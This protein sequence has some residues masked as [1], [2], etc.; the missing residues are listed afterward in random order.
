MVQLVLALFAGA[1]IGPQQTPQARLPVSIDVTTIR[2]L[3][4]QHD[5]RWP[6]LDTVARDLVEQV[7]GNSS[8]Q[9]RDPVT[10]ILAWTFDPQTWMYQ[11]VFSIKN[12]ELR[13][14][15]KLSDT[16]QAF[17]YIELI[18]HKPLLSLIDDLAHIERGRKLNPLEA[19][20]SDINEKL[21]IFQAIIS[22]WSI[23]LIPNPDDEG[24]DWKTIP[25]T[26]GDSAEKSDAEAAFSDLRTAFLADGGPAFAAASERLAAAL[27]ALPA[28]TRPTPE[29]IRTELLYNRIQPFR[30]AWMV[31]AVGA[32]LAALALFVRRKWF[33]GL[34][35]AG[36]M[37]GF[38][39]L[40]YGLWLRWQVAGRI[41]ASNMFESLLFLSWGM[42]LFAILAICVFR[43][44]MIP[45]TASFMAA[46][47]LFLADI[48]PLDSFVRPIVPVLADTVWMTIHVPVIMISYS[49]LALGVLIAHVQ[50]VAMAILPKRRDLAVAIDSVHYYYI[51]VGSILLL[52]GIVTGSMWAASSWGRYWGW[53]AKEVWSLVALLGYLT[54]LHVRIAREKIPAWAY[55][56]AAILT[57]LLFVMIQ[58]ALD[59]ITPGKVLA[60]TGVLAAMALLVLAPGPFATAAKS[61]L[62]FWLIIMTYVG[63]NYVLGTGLHSYGFGTGAV[64]RYMFGLGGADLLL[65]AILSILYLA[66][67]SRAAPAAAVAVPVAKPA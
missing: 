24:G 57:A 9:G 33:D 61:I 60:L 25:L 20:V 32:C 12:A 21:G 11:P 49:V 34:A 55:A 22:G 46:L 64:A 58:P 48:L 65:V 41:P 43:S 66:R 40:T 28:A 30:T 36:L 39:L 50:L 54:I 16:R 52:A 23:R 15:L 59:P 56:V 1:L 47:S 8:F 5:G 10:M 62:C 7:S 27:A 38:A 35:M 51:H 45:L 63:V 26:K 29:H 19:K 67:R 44:R 17:S 31:M 37:A 6:P 3:T 4:T 14:E 42:G 53:D 13:G 18:R 2:G